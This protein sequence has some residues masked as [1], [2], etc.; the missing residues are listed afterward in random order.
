VEYEDRLRIATPEG[1]ELELTL[2]G[3]GSRS[4]C[5]AVDL[6]IQFVLSLGATL[7]ITA[8]SGGGGWVLALLPVTAFLII[9]GYDVAFE[10]LGGGRTPGKRLNGLRVVRT[11]GRPVTFVPSVIRNVMRI[12]D[13]LPT[14]YGVGILAVMLSARNQ[15]LGDMAAGTLVVRERTVE[16]RRDAAGPESSYVPPLPASHPAMA[17]DLSAIALDDL[18]VVRRFLDRRWELD[19]GP[20][21]KL[22]GEL[23]ARLGPRV[24]GVPDHLSPEQFLEFVVQVKAARG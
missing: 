7:L 12:I 5:A 6:T 22:A 20:R 8:A 4:L 1:I 3:P 11:G 24:A 21:A 19:A 14:L 15:R 23:A 16:S 18:L 17:W 9:F 13:F 2:A 10:V